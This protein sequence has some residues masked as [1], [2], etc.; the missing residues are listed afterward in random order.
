MLKR[1]VLMWLTFH[2][3]SRMKGGRSDTRSLAKWLLY[4][5][6]VV[7]C[8]GA[9]SGGCNV[10]LMGKW[11]TELNGRL[12]QAGHRRKTALRTSSGPVCIR[13]ELQNNLHLVK[14]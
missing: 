7:V 11:M 12:M 3:N 9:L 1:F 5:G 14:I 13:Q 2:L 10:D 6:A 4:D 8:S